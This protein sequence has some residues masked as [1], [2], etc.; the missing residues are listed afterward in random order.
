MS[1]TRLLRSDDQIKDLLK[2]YFDK[3]RLP[4]GPEMKAPPKTE[5]YAM[6]GTAF[7]YLLRFEVARLNRDKTEKERRGGWIAESAINLIP[8]PDLQHK[9][10]D[11]VETARKRRDQY[12]STGE[13]TGELLRSVIHLARL[14]PIVRA[15]RGHDRIGSEINP[16]DID[17]LHQLLAT[18]PRD[19]FKAEKRC[20]LNPDFG[21]GSMLV[22]GA[23]ADLMIDDTII[24]FKTTKKWTV[25]RRVFDQLLG[26]YTLMHI[27]DIRHV[28]PKPEVN[29]LSVYFSRHGKMHNYKIQNLIEKEDFSEFRD[30]FERRCKDRRPPIP[31]ESNSD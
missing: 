8:D 16:A 20:L 14:D 27:D 25:R 7:D 9:A 3:P 22:G 31:G 10:Q 2:T 19:E 18:V 30:K 23:D 5:N 15:R 13:A 28:D 26:Y 6:I 12:I 24:D 1:L 4:P 11:M 29:R 17:D 21:S